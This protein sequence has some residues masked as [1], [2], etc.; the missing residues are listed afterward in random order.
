M[1]AGNRDK[2]T[3]KSGAKGMVV[4]HYDPMGSTKFSRNE[5]V[6]VTVPRNVHELK[7]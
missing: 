7:R 5:K 3:V 2:Y 4:D 1:Y 6:E